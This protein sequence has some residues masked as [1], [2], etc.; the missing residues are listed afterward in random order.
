MKTVFSN[1]YDCIH[2]FAQQKSTQGQTSNVFWY[3]KKLYS[4]GYHFLLAEI[5]ND[6]TIVI[7]DSYYSNTTRKHQSITRQ[8]TRQYQQI[9]TS[10]HCIAT[11]ISELNRLSNKLKNARKPEI[12]INDALALI[13]KHEHEQ[14]IYKTKHI[15]K[16]YKAQ[17]RK[18]KK[19]FSLNKHELKDK[20]AEIVKLEKKQREAAKSK[21]IKAFKSFEAYDA[22]KRQANIHTDLIR[23]SKCGNFIETSQHV[24][25]PFNDAKKLYLAL[26]SGKNIV[27]ET[28]SHYSI[29]KV[30]DN[31]VKIGCHNLEITEIHSIFENHA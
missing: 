1:A 27:G 14:S 19:L 15:D 2:A 26:K 8:A 17:L 25:V 28:I 5:I 22:L 20:F 11:V 24:I 13:S 10:S 4:Y 21:Y 16:A 3:G 30:S 23:V 31:I 12:Y 9:F 29:Y 18:F 6:D 7:N